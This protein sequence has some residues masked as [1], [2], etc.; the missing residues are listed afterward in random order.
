MT[1]SMITAI[2]TNVLLDILVPNE[3][4]CDASVR[5]LEDAYTA[6][7][8]VICGLVYAELC[9]QFITQRE[10]DG[11]LESNGRSLAGTSLAAETSIRPVL[12]FKDLHRGSWRE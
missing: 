4:F 6:G 8:L 3:K 5:A 2:D 1:R 11:F 9:I 12:C 7:S 10:C